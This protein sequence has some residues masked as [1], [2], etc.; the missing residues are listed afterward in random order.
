MSDLISLLLQG[1]AVGAIYGLV[2]LSFV[3]IYKCSRVLNIAQGE[4]VTVGAFL[5]YI[6]A[7]QVGVPFYIALVL[8]FALSYLLGH[9][10]Q[11]VFL[12]PLV[13]QPLLT[14]IMMTIAIS[15]ILY[16]LV[17]IFYGADFYSYPKYLPETALTIGGVSLGS[18]Y[19][20]SLIL[21]GVVS[22]LALAFFRFTNT[23]ISMRAVADDETAAEGMGIDVRQM[24]GTAWGLSFIVSAAAGVLLG[25]VISVYYGLSFIGLKSIAAVIVGGLESLGG[26]M[27]GGLIIGVV[28]SLGGMYISRLHPFLDGSKEVFAYVVLLIAL[29]IKPYGFFGERRIERI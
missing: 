15:S 22:A 26:A 10:L 25:T 3:I 12:R 24:Y 8:A 5:C 16:S 17:I 27:L 6:F 4:L 21:A 7:V 18:E 19:L 23:G 13:G 9:V 14:I 29:L 2:A 11:R 28:E 1:L 20:W